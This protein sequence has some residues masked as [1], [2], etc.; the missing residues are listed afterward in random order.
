MGSPANATL[1][2]QDY[3]TI[4]APPSPPAEL[5]A[6]A[7]STSRIDLAWLDQ[8][9]NEAGY[10][11]ERSPDHDAWLRIAATGANVTNCGDTGLETDTPYCYRVAATN[12]VGLSAWVEVCC[13]TLTAYA[14]WRLLH[15]TPEEATNAMVSGE[16]ADPDKDGS[17]NLHE[18]LAGT[19]PKDWSSCL[20][21]LDIAPAIGAT[22][23]V[24]H[25]QSA[26]GRV[27][28]VYVSTNLTTDP[29]TEEIAPELP[30]TPP[31]NVY[32]DAVD[33]AGSVFYR[34]GLE[35]D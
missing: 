28:H 10:V 25:W 32:T 5:T 21:L 3:G 2:V 24:L 17:C 34:V 4:P 30:A 29:F 26:T 31:V 22:G 13:T 11:V 14:E 6:A 8:A 20:R 23:Y 18:F 33:R 16:S 35:L 9:T 7:V 12:A 27:Y 19:H 15:F 1:N